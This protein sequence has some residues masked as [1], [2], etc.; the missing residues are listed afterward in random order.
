MRPTR[1]EGRFLYLKLTDDRSPP[2]PQNTFTATPRLVFGEITG[3]CSPAKLTLKTNHHIA[4]FLSSAKV[5]Q[6]DGDI[7]IHW[8]LRGPGPCSLVWWGAVPPRRACRGGPFQGL[9]V[10][11]PAGVTAGRPQVGG[12][13]RAGRRRGLPGNDPFPENLQ[14]PNSWGTCEPELPTWK[15]DG[16]RMPHK[17]ARAESARKLNVPGCG[18][19]SGSSSPGISRGAGAPMTSGF[20]KSNPDLVGSAEFLF[21]P[22]W[23][24]SS[25]SGWC[26]L[27]SI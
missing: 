19:E 23:W 16:R 6:Q 9:W 13:R 10:G 25:G 7:L 14:L 8:D 1:I 20:Y 3:Y 22:C 15:Q 2:H 26:N 17:K 21:P 4:E 12:D 18:N 24:Q 5:K 27:R 11:G